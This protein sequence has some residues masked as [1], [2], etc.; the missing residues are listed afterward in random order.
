METTRRFKRSSFSLDLLGS[1][2]SFH[3]WTDGSLWNGW[4]KP[5][6]EFY[7]AQKLL[8]TLAEAYKQANE[9]LQAWY[10][11]EEDSFNFIL[12]EETEPECYPAETIEFEGRELRVYSIGAGAW[13]WEELVISK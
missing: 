11:N 4:S 8:E 2:I 5:L 9:P 10:D 12:P 6:F 1:D 7:E 3:G 13:I